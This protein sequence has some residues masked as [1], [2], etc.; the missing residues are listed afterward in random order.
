MS[1]PHPSL[2]DIDALWEYDKPE[3]SEQKFRA[4]LPQTSGNRAYHIELLTQIARC[5]GLQRKFDEAHTTLDEAESL[6]TDD[7]A[8]P[9]VRTMLERGRV[10][11]SSKNPDQARVHFI[12]AWATARECHEDGLAVDAAHMLGIVESGEKGLEWN[13]TALDLAEKSDNPRAQKWRGSLYN[14]MGWTYHDQFG[15]YDKALALFER[16]LAFRE[17]QGEPEQAR[18]ARWCVARC[19][20]SLGQ[21]G[22]AL[23]MQRKLLAESSPQGKPDPYVHEELGECLLSLSKPDEARPYFALAYEELSRDES[24]AESEPARL[25]RLRDL[26]GRA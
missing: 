18:I 14:N 23:T 12:Q 25:A 7:L 6:L 19:L 16:A 1:E 10:F 20:R 5:Q 22:E 21:V 15:Q 13:S 9:R 4:L 3:V 8:R 11:N 2:P 26:G 17:E 24:F